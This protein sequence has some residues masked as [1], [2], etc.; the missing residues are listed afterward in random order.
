MKFSEKQKGI[1]LM[2]L[3]AFLFSAMQVTVSLSD[4]S[5]GTME[6]VFFRNS[7]SMIIALVLIK[8]KNL[9]LFGRREDQPALFWRSFLGFLGV[10]FAF[11]ALREASQADVTILNKLNPFIITL[12]SV[13]F[14]KEK[15]SKIQIPALIIAFGGAFIATGPSFNSDFIPLL[16]SFMS[17]VVS[18]IA[19]TLLGYLKDKVDG[20]TIIMHFSVFSMVA[21]APFMLRGFN[22]PSPYELLLLILIGIFGSFGQIAVTYSFRMAP[23]S[24]VSIYN[25]SGIIFS[26]LMGYFLLHESIPIRSVV[27]GIL[28]V[29]AS[30]L[31]YVFVE[32][33]GD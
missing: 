3:S 33:K 27:G 24:E 4:N 16:L 8:R 28:V 2:L 5:I 18:G 19:Y 25:Y 10:V 6:Q 13:V 26:M 29:V 11:Y 9:P 7:I 20:L 31:V 30:I 32:N 23:A 1:F 22:I 17:A 14:L 15:L 12:L 21:S